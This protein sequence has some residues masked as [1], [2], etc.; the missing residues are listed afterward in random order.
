MGSYK[1]ELSKN[2]QNWV[3]VVVQ[4]E[5]EKK[6]KSQLIPTNNKIVGRLLRIT[7]TGMA[8]KP[9]SIKEVEVFGKTLN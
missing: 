1:I 8:N 3:T 4:K 2:N 6:E 5:G 9:T 7:F